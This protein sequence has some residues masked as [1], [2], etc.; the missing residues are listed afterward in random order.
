MAVD[1]P[2]LAEIVMGFA[3]EFF[4]R[5][6]IRSVIFL[7][8]VRDFVRVEWA[9]IDGDARFYEAADEADSGIR[10]G[11]RVD[12]AE[13]PVFAEDIRVDVVGRAVDIDVAAREVGAKQGGA[14]IGGA[15]KEFIDEF[16][17][18]LLQFF[19]TAD[20]IE[21]FGVVGAAVGGIE[22]KGDRFKGP[23]N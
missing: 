6:M 10:A 8:P 21:I 15:I 7:N 17:L 18:G 20:E 11:G 12:L 14:V 13:G 16:I 9:V 5:F 4:E 1:V 3:D 19:K 2:D 22:N 23:E